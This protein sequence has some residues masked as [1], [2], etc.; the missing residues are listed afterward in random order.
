MKIRKQ[1]VMEKKEDLSKHLNRIRK[2]ERKVMNDLALSYV[3][4]IA[5]SDFKKT[6]KFDT[7]REHTD[8]IGSAKNY[9]EK[10]IKASRF[11]NRIR[12]LMWKVYKKRFASLDGE[13]TYGCSSSEAGYRYFLTRKF[14][15]IKSSV[16]IASRIFS[17]AKREGF[18]IG[19]P[20]EKKLLLSTTFLLNDE[21]KNH[22]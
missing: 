15:N 16:Q 4:D 14:I 17:E 12:L 20:V 22:G 13:G 10:S 8:I 19:T 21:E 1:T 5:N 3:E 18:D 6:I 9:F 7:I 11:I 2:E